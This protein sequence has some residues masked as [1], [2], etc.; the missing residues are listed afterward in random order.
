MKQ[1][2]LQKFSIPDLLQAMYTVRLQQGKDPWKADGDPV[3]AD[4]ISKWIAYFE[5][6]A[7]KKQWKLRWNPQEAIVIH[8]R[9]DDKA[10]LSIHDQRGT[11]DSP[12][13]Q[14]YMGDDKLKKILILLHSFF[15]EKK[16][17]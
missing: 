9:L 8:V 1:E 5:S 3:P 14:G 16:C 13:V 7:Q 12:R 15:P 4:F 2:A 10:P 17:I 6:V 11:G